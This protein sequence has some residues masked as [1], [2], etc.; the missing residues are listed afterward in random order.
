MHMDV[1]IGKEWLTLIGS[2]VAAIAGV[3]N[4]AIQIRGKRDK[5]IVRLGSFSASPMQE[6]A[7]HVISLSD[8]Q[9]KLSDWGFVDGDLRLRSI[10]SELEHNDFYGHSSIASG[11]STLDQRNA[12]YQI[13][14]QRRDTPIGA[15]ATSVAQTR[16]RIHFSSSTPYWKRIVVRLK[17]LKRNWAYGY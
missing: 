5:F 16:P 9:I 3:W 2:A 10:P 7:M 8:H 4:L 6:E 11:T 13:A 1:G 15:F 17:S 12:L 14:Y